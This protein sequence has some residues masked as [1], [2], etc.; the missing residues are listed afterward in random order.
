V[1]RVVVVVEEK[2]ER[3]DDEMKM[4]MKMILNGLGWISMNV[5]FEEKSNE[6]EN[7]IK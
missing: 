2:Q 4:K 3:V 6:R 1:E 7:E 5:F